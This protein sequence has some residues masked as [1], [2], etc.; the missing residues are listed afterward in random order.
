MKYQPKLLEL[1]QD[2]SIAYSERYSFM[3]GISYLT[4]DMT[5]SLEEDLYFKGIISRTIAGGNVQD[6]P[7]TR[8]SVVQKHGKPLDS[9]RFTSVGIGRERSARVSARGY[10]GLLSEESF[11][12]GVYR[13]RRVY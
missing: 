10:G 7:C 9:W 4:P 11:W 13:R 8:S 2:L 6:N 3:N 1:P 12:G 5:T